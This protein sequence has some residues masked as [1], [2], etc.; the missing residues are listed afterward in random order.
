[1]CWGLIFGV[2]L[3]LWGIAQ[4]F[5]TL[6]HITIPIFG[7][8]LGVF[9]LYIG[10][11]LITGGFKGKYY[12]RCCSGKFSHCSSSSCSTTMG[13][14][15]IKVEDENLTG[16]GEPLEY[17]TVFGKS[18]VDLRSMSIEKLRSL[19]SPLI[20]TIDTVFGKTDVK[21]NKDVPVRIFVK[22]A[23]GNSVL[24]DSSS[25]VF[26]SHTYSSHG[27]ESPLMLIY[28]STVFGAT[29]VEQE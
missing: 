28:V 7:V 3:V 6:F 24:P 22:G 14:S 29:E 12:W 11:N 5:E 23:F 18:I 9:L 15:A 2:L 26:G 16:Q 27:A 17:K 13:S 25:I 10:F 19:G 1:M 4:I 8:I 21:L 20:V